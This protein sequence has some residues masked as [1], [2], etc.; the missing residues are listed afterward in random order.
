MPN[1]VSSTDVGEKELFSVALAPTYVK[2]TFA[3]AAA[4][5]CLGAGPVNARTFLYHPFLPPI[6]LISCV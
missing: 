2:R 6:A 3:M 5:P 4:N 1:F